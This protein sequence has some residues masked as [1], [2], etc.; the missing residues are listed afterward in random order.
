M[1]VDPPATSDGA[2][3]LTPPGA[4]YCVQRPFLRA[5]TVLYNITGCT[6]L[7]VAQ[8][9]RLEAAGAAEGLRAAV[10]VQRPQGAGKTDAGDPA[11]APA[12]G[13]SVVDDDELL[14]KAGA[15]PER[16]REV[17]AATAL[18]D[19]MRG[20]AGASDARGSS[21]AAR[22]T[23]TADAAGAGASAAPATAAR[24]GSDGGGSGGS[25]GCSVLGVGASGSFTSSDTLSLLH[26]VG[27]GG[28]RLSGGQR[29][30]VALARE[31]YAGRS[32]PFI[33]D[34]P[35]DA[36]DGRVARHVAQAVFGP[37]G[38]LRAQ[39]RP[40]VL[41]TRDE[42]LV[43]ASARVADER[44]A[45]G[46]A[47]G[48]GTGRGVLCLESGD[49]V[50]VVAPRPRSRRGRSRRKPAAQAVGPSGGG[51]AHLRAASEAASG[52]PARAS[53]PV[54][55]SP[56]AKPAAEAAAAGTDPRRCDSAESAST[57]TVVSAA[58]LL[59]AGPGAV[60]AAL[61]GRAVRIG[62]E[63]A[64]ATA[65]G[66]RASGERAAKADASAVTQ[67]G[68]GGGSSGVGSGGWA[69]DPAT[70]R[71]GRRVGAGSHWPDCCRLCSCAWWPGPGSRDVFDTSR[72]P[73]WR[74]DERA[75]TLVD[76][77][78]GAA[79]LG[80]AAEGRGGSIDAAAAIA[81]SDALA[82][83]PQ[84]TVPRWV[85]GA[86]LRRAGGPWVLAATALLAVAVQATG[87]GVEVWLSLWA[88]R[89]AAAAGSAG[90]G[91]GPMT[92]PSVAAAGRWGSPAEATV[93]RAAPTARSDSCVA[94][95]APG[96]TLSIEERRP[97]DEPTP[98]LAS[99]AAA[100]A[101]PVASAT[102]E[103][104][105]TAGQSATAPVGLSPARHT[106]RAA[107][108]VGD[109]AMAPGDDSWT[110]LLVFS[111]LSCLAIALSTALTCAW[112]RV[113]VTASRRAVDDA[114]AHVLAASQR[115]HDNARPGDILARLGDDAEGMDVG[116]PSQMRQVTR[117]ALAASAQLIAVAVGA[118]VALPLALVLAGVFGAFASKFRAVSREVS[119]AEAA[120]ESPM[121]EL[122][123]AASLNA[124][125]LRAAGSALSEAE[126]RRFGLVMD[127]LGSTERAA[128]ALDAWLGMRAEALGAVATA[129]LGAVALL[130]RRGPLA[131]SVPL[132][133]EGLLYLLVTYAAG[134]TQT[135]EGLLGAV[136]EAEAEGASVERVLRFAE[137]A[138]E[139]RDSGPWKDPLAASPAGLTLV[140]ALGDSE[141]GGPGFSGPGDGGTSA[142]GQGGAVAHAGASREM[143]ATPRRARVPGGALGTGADGAG[144]AAPVAALLE[145]VRIRFG[146]SAR[147]SLRGVSLAVG[148]G[149]VVG[150]VGRTG[151]GK[152]LIV[153]ALLGLYP[154]ETTG[155]V[156][157]LGADVAGGSQ[158]EEELARG[159]RLAAVRA[160]AESVAGAAGSHCRAG[161]SLPPAGVAAVPH[162][163]PV[164]GPTIRDQLCLG[165]DGERMG[166][167]DEQA[168]WA[169]RA[170]GAWEWA[171]RSGGLDAAVGP[172]RDASE[173]RLADRRKGAARSS[174]ASA[175]ESGR[176]SGLAGSASGSS[177]S[178]SGS[179]SGSSSGSSS[180]SDGSGSS[181]D[182][183]LVLGGLSE[184]QGQQLA[185]ARALLHLRCRHAGLLLADE[186]G[187]AL[188]GRAA[189]VMLAALATE[190][191]RGGAGALLVAHALEPLANARPDRVIVVHDGEIAESGA[192][193]S[194]LGKPQGA[195]ALLAASQGIAAWPD[196]DETDE[197]VLRGGQSL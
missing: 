104:S 64:A 184:A 6:V 83:T 51:G 65:A 136:A 166:P 84:G 18:L 20:A 90:P 102:A 81:A 75:G 191:R 134:L 30:R 154:A 169:L 72:G 73:T 37:G 197:P 168:L 99:A 26:D 153:A 78:D 155:T 179:H 28:R 43:A 196:S 195:F 100:S 41:A 14:R 44:S 129:G 143:M 82:A 2:A 77:A 42:S 76:D 23:A 16:L 114:T 7:S 19:E 87:T 144:L 132:G 8:L 94:D 187:S 27:E 142:E 119:R 9:D 17:L 112:A 15:D 97:N 181:S 174:S 113:G 148:R 128:W 25:G 59:A 190:A 96:R 80:P 186:C 185:A 49:V 159:R 108:A 125:A 38:L 31:L 55:A 45:E 123:S 46:G 110:G 149:E 182:G 152:S 85:W 57:V 107:A 1:D 4:S 137:G 111:G 53:L 29:A 156:R 56:A 39:R 146:G 95:V 74:A 139:D 158:A 21:A 151:Q 13:C 48:G 71:R 116:L 105:A 24:L 133:V 92:G 88:E 192:P 126:Q 163:G 66:T 3:P 106:A 22:P 135:L 118:P 130:A 171:G 63:A 11:H 127:Q 167:T 10:A 60:G 147:D 79:E 120:A 93:M 193:R 54:E 67:L 178:S 157:V 52:A 172:E 194:L 61:A 50:C 62:S 138:L 177:G 131:S 36:L 145:G 161:R 160:S 40:I 103:Q 34:C 47:I 150:L 69:P 140:K 121:M 68:G 33:A 32:G 98:T 162:G 124:A 115:F 117:A 122:V 5:G 188:P 170:V 189:G 35:L 180:G 165:L 58:A 141:H 70:G 164:L 183:K 175:V 101:L 91:E 176:E 86:C 109:A 12:A 89:A 173:E